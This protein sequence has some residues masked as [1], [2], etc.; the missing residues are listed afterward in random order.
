MLG[1]LECKAPGF[2][3]GKC[4]YDEIQTYDGDKQ[5]TKQPADGEDNS[6]PAGFLLL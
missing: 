3:T 5:T 1:F 6:L 4:N 2:Y